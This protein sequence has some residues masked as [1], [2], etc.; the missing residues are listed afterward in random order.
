MGSDFKLLFGKRSLYFTINLK[1]RVLVYML[2]CS[3]FWILPGG[4]Y[5]KKES[6]QAVPFLHSY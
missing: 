2:R 6:E 4:T 5:C 1:I 3:L